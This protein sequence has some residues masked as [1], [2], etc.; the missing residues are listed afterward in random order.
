MYAAQPLSLTPAEEISGWWPSERSTKSRMKAFLSRAKLEKLSRHHNP[1]PLTLFSVGV[2]PNASLTGPP[3]PANVDAV[4]SN[5]Q[6]T[7]PSRTRTSQKSQGKHNRLMKAQKSLP[8]MFK[9][10]SHPSEEVVS[11]YPIG[12]VLLPPTP[13]QH[14]SP[15]AASFSADFSVHTVNKPNYLRER[16]FSD[17]HSV[18]TAYTHFSSYTSSPL[19]TPY[20]SFSS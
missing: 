17:N 6:K 12:P 8:N 20:S 14:Y 19:H 4:E 5:S 9:A 1:E 13:Q 16:S 7:W 15:I 2:K 11:D 10:F 18:S 3:T